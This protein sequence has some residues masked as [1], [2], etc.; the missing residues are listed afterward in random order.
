MQFHIKQDACVSCLACLRVCP[1]NAVAVDAE[2]VH[3]LDEACIRCGD[4]VPACPHD[5][6]EA[7]GE[8]EVAAALAA[9]G[10]AMLILSVEAVVHFYPATPEQLVN[11]CYEAGFSMVHR[12]VIGDELVAQGYSRLWEDEGW[13]TMIRSTCPVVVET[14][15][16]NYPELL[17]YLAP[18]KTPLGAEAAY[19]RALYGA[20]VKLVYAGVC[21]ADGKDAVDATLTF[22]ELERLLRGRGVDVAAQERFYRRMPEE[23]RRHLSAAGGLPLPVLKCE[24]Q[25][26]RRFRKI[27]GLDGL[28]AVARAVAVDGLELGFV[29][30]LACDGCLAHPLL[31]PKEELFWRR[32]VLQAS[33]PPRS[34]EPVVDPA[35]WVDV[36]ASFWPH[37]NGR[38]A[39]AEEVAAVVDEIGRAP[40]G[41]PWDCGACGYDTCHAFALARLEGRAS[42]R[43]CPP[44][45]ER[46]AA[47]AEREAAM[48]GL[49][50]LGSPRLLKE[51]L[52]QELARSR[53]SGEPFAILFADLDQFKLVND[54]YG[55]EAGND[56][57]QTVARVLESAVRSSD[58]AIRYGG[59]EFVVFLMATDD[60]GARHVG[61]V[62]RH[63]VEKAGLEKGYP[64]G[65]VTISVG[66]ATFDPHAGV[67]ENVLEVADR[68]LYRAKAAGG[69]RVA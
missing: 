36:S 34:R 60:V 16:R 37:E 15:R 17:P 66:V 49:T 53:R 54:R 35:V 64:V 9:S 51:R 43:Q 22:Q 18:V 29:D 28:R 39:S 25:A 27:R 44:Y 69:N 55:H 62:V 52:R 19:L 10:E 38:M 63:R 61:E 7:V 5:A 47:E 42:F 57:L 4:C 8:V 2:R 23:R 12:G 31:G 21:L 48:D 3:I 45:Q 11:A 24:P 30:I 6:I 32:Q 41:R 58:V 68:A 50:G 67:G 56:V 20:G 33:E 65:F 40:G 1:S 26:S 13:G 46:R 14:I 59:D